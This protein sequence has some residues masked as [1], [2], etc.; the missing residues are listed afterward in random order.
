MTTE[1]EPGTL[2]ALVDDL[3]DFWRKLRRDRTLVDAARE[4]VRVP[5]RTITVKGEP[6]PESPAKGKSS[7]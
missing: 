2:A 5:P 3:R 4:F 1:R 6:V 7:P